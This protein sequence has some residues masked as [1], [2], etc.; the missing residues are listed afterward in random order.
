M[1]SDWITHCKNYQAEHGCSYK[2]AMKQA[3]ATYTGGSLKSVVKKARHVGKHA[4]NRV[5]HLDDDINKVKKSARKAVKVIDRVDDKLGTNVGK[6]VR[7]VGNQVDAE[8]KR[9][10]IGRK[11]KNVAKRVGRDAAEYGLDALDLTEPEIGV[12]VELAKR[13][14]VGKKLERK[15]MKGSGKGKL[16]VGP[17]PYLTGGSFLTHD[18]MRGGCRSCSGGKLAPGHTEASVLHPSHPAAQPLKLKS[19]SRSQ[20]EN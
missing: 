20:Y 12:A 8:M 9:Q 5:H 7:K 18:N 16:G 6:S 15:V 4:S 13:N 11:A 14:Q 17:N 19:Y 10:H 3:K 2:D 1:T